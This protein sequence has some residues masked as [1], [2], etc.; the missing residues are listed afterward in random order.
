MF[1]QGYGNGA[2]GKYSNSNNQQHYKIKCS[3]EQHRRGEM[4]IAK[5]VCMR[6]CVGAMRNRGIYSFGDSSILNVK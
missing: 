6:A 5:T 4:T 1:A 3:M 2:F